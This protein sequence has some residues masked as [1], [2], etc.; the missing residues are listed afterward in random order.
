MWRRTRLCG[1]T[2]YRVI[3]YLGALTTESM[4]WQRSNPVLLVTFY[5]RVFLLERYLCLPFSLPQLLVCSFAL[6]LEYA[7]LL[8]EFRRFRTLSVNVLWP[9][10]RFIVHTIYQCLVF[11]L[12]AAIWVFVLVYR[13]YFLP[14]LTYALSALW[15][16]LCKKTEERLARIIAR[17]GDS[18]EWPF[19]HCLDCSMLWFVNIA[20]DIS[21]W[22]ANCTACLISW[23]EFA[24]RITAGQTSLY[25]PNT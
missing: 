23:F 5:T 22:L 6:C 4:R 14:P 3:N 19:N 12:S 8:V 15:L 2:R 9:P 7:C 16:F 1:G 21:G 24:R 10:V 20:D 25:Q 18:R 11:N 13:L 17:L